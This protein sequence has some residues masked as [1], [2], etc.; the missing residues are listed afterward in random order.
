MKKTTK[1]NIA[2][3]VVTFILTIISLPQTVIFLLYS[4]WS[5]T[6]VYMQYVAVIL[7]VSVYGIVWLMV[8]NYVVHQKMAK[9]KILAVFLFP[10]ILSGATYAGTL[11]YD[12]YQDRYVKVSTEVDLEQYRP[13]QS[14]LLATLDQKASLQ[15]EEPVITLDGATAFY[16][17]YASFAQAIYPEKEY[18]LYDGDVTCYTTPDAYRRLLEKERDMIFVFEPSKEQQSDFDNANETMVKTPIGK[19]SFVFFVNAANPIDSLTSEQ[20]R[21][22][23]SG[24]ITNWKE[25]GGKDETI[26]AYQ[27]P[28][29]SGSQTALLSMMKDTPVMQP[30][31]EN[32]VQGMGGIISQ[33]ADYQNRENAIGYSFRYFAKEMVNNKEIKLLKIDGISP[34]KENVRNDS[35]PFIFPFYAIHLESNQNERID[36]LLQWITSSQGKELI[37]KSGYVTY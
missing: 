32:V 23:Y 34:D 9:F 17:V 31:E 2:L 30:I 11:A 6:H 10:L 26:K 7:S 12:A 18:P 36:T 5:S 14:K 35:Y 21:D 27:R 4:A 28:E 29:G 13:F 15:I 8:I 24:K 22:I 20:I 33:T 16:P 37:E 25:V 1:I 19:E 3:I